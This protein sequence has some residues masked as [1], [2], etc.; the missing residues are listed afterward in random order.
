MRYLCKLKL[1]FLQSLMVDSS[2]SCV[3]GEAPLDLSLLNIGGVSMGSLQSG[4]ELL[5]SSTLLST[6][7]S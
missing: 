6:V 1:I 5:F 2:P 3:H 4:Y 7:S